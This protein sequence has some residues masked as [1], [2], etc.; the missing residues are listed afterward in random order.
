MHRIRRSCNK[1]KLHFQRIFKLYSLSIVIIGYQFPFRQQSIGAF[2]P[3]IPV[4]RNTILRELHRSSCRLLPE[5]RFQHTECTFCIGRLHRVHYLHVVLY[6]FLT[7]L[8]YHL[9]IVQ[10]DGIGKIHFIAHHHVRTLQVKSQKT[11]VYPA[12]Y[13]CTSF[14]IRNFVNFY[15]FF[16]HLENRVAC[17]HAELVT[18][19]PIDG[20]SLFHR[21]EIIGRRH[22][23]FIIIRIQFAFARSRCIQIIPQSMICKIRYA[24]LTQRVCKGL[25]HPTV[26]SGLSRYSHNKKGE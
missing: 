15:R 10:Q 23:E 13:H 21:R 19:F 25:H 18:R 14:H 20:K 3:L 8:V 22:K 11:L 16:F 4:V 1:A 26:V 17:I 9:N 12:V 6:L 7:R 5:I 2:T 24:Q